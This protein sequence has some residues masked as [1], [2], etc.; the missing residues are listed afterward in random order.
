MIEESLRK[1][2][3]NAG[4]TFLYVSIWDKSCTSKMVQGDLI[5]WDL[6]N[7]IAWALLLRG[8]FLSD[9]LQCLTPSKPCCFAAFLTWGSWVQA[10]VGG[11]VCSG[12]SQAAGSVQL[13]QEGAAGKVQVSLRLTPT[14][15]ESVPWGYS[16]GFDIQEGVAPMNLRYRLG[17]CWRRMQSGKGFVT[18]HRVSSRGQ[19]EQLTW[20]VD[21]ELVHRYAHILWL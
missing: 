6:W 8:G 20:L 4:R 2:M 14:T 11:S 17:P 19:V 3:S 10:Q 15:K 18:D 12:A 16:G 5:A 13:R 7:P 9:V 21:I 1:K